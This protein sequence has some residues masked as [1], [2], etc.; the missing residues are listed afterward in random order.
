MGPPPVSRGG[1]GPEEASPWFRYLSELKRHLV[2][3]SD[4]AG[5]G[6]A[7]S[8]KTDVKDLRSRSDSREGEDPVPSFLCW[9]DS[10]RLAEPLSRVFFITAP[11]RVDRGEPS[12][13]GDEGSIRRWL[14]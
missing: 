6:H 4:T 3:P 8:G 1:A 11:V 5:P 12:P 13:H 9:L 7:T 2:L 14:T 10:R